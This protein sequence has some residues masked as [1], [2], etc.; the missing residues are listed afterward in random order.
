[1]E[2]NKSRV[3]N[4][5]GEDNLIIE[6]VRVVSPIRQKAMLKIVPVPMN[7]EEYVSVVVLYLRNA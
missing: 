4:F 1:M 7:H 2:R 6:H 5:G 3:I